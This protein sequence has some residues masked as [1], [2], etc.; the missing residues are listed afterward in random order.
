MHARDFRFV[1]SLFSRRRVYKVRNYPNFTKMRKFSPCRNFEELRHLIVSAVPHEQCQLLDHDHPPPFPSL[2]YLASFQPTPARTHAQPSSPPLRAACTKLHSQEAPQ[3]L[4]SQTTACARFV[5]LAFRSSSRGTQLLM[6][7]RTKAQPITPVEHTASQRHTQHFTARHCVPAATGNPWTEHEVH[8]ANVG[9]QHARSPPSTFC[10]DRVLVTGA[11]FRP[12]HEL[13]RVRHLPKPT[14]SPHSKPD[15][16]DGTI[17]SS[18]IASVGF[19]RTVCKRL[20]CSTK[21][22]IRDNWCVFHSPLIACVT[23]PA[24]CANLL[25]CSS[26]LLLTTLLA[27]ADCSHG[28]CSP[29]NENGTS[30]GTLVCQ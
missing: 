1:V 6:Q 17:P 5:D 21:R 20:G 30:P 18:P 2:P 29:S 28:S 9:D 23:P 7:H 8:T 24:V 22:R 15:V 10:L 19:A 25:A 12:T 4:P 11:S 3:P 27:F 16:H 13:W 26:T 14:A